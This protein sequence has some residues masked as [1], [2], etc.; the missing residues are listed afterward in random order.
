MSLLSQNITSAVSRHP[1]NARLLEKPGIDPVEDEVKDVLWEMI[2][3]VHNYDI[4]AADDWPAIPRVRRRSIAERGECD[5]HQCNQYLS[6]LLLGSDEELS[7]SSISSDSDESD[8][9]D[10]PVGERVCK[11][12]HHSESVIQSRGFGWEDYLDLDDMGDG[13]ELVCRSCVV[14]KQLGTAS[15]FYCTDCGYSE[16]LSQQYHGEQLGQ[17]YL[18]G[19]TRP[20]YQ[21]ENTRCQGCRARV[22]RYER[23]EEQ[24]VNRVLFPEDDEEVSEEWAETYEGEFEPEEDMED[25]NEEK[26]LRVKKT[27]QEMGEVL[28]DIKDKITEGEYLKLM[29]GLQSVTNEM[30]N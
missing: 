15:D 7:I 8:L 16:P 6:N 30:N 17:F 9:T 27:V 26:A 3:M 2:E 1:G 18:E 4:V 10:T 13:E 21:D 19:E 12:C 23:E 14:G 25:N 28:F 24:G 29:D 11:C 22:E 20:D 5:C